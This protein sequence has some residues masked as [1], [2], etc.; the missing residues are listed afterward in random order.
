MSTLSLVSQAVISVSFVPLWQLF[1][2]TLSYRNLDRQGERTKRKWTKTP[3][4]Y[5]QSSLCEEGSDLW[6]L[7]I[8]VWGGKSPLSGV[9]HRVRREVSS[10][11]CPSLCENGSL[12][13]QASITVWGG[14][15]P[16]TAVLHVW[17][18]KWSLTCVCL[19]IRVF[20]WRNLGNTTK[21]WWCHFK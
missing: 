19:S 10:D 9:H 18:A 13:W 12:L 14:K 4:S 21:N 11:R 17:T 6:Q 5:A 20:L 8:T 3:A 2:E 1:S 15:S 7:P 16:L